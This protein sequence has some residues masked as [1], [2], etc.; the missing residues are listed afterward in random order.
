MS[1]YERENR[2]VLRCCLKT[3][4]DSATVTVVLERRTILFLRTIPQ[5]HTDPCPRYV[6][7]LYTTQ[8]SSNMLHDTNVTWCVVWHWNMTTQSVINTYSHCCTDSISHRNSVP[9]CIC[10]CRRSADRD[11][12]MAHSCV[13]DLRCSHDE[14]VPSC[15]AQNTVT[16]QL[17]T[18]HMVHLPAMHRTQSQHSC[19]QTHGAP[20]CSAQ[21]AVTTQSCT[22]ARC[23]CSKPAVSQCPAAI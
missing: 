3:V 6:T 18:W 1:G 9:W 2:N 15:S 4:S 13:H 10:M 8:R 12:H 21:N 20:S 16:T 19:A 5:Y 14:P 7:N 22:D 23:A 17:C 11:G